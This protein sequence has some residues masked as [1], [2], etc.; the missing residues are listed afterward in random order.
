M[1]RVL[2]GLSVLIWQ[3]AS[4][5]QAADPREALARARVLYNQG[6]FDAAVTA[7]EEARTAP[8]LASAADLIAARAELERHRASAAPDD[9]VRARER[10]GRIDP[11][12]FTP[13]ERLEFVVGLGQALYFDG[14]TGA[15]AVVFESVLSGPHALPPEARERVLDW[16]ANA[17]DRDAHPRPDIE[18]QG[19]YQRIRDRMASEL[20]AR[21]G[22]S[23]ASYWVSAAARG[24][25][26]LQAA[27]D[28]AQAAWVN[29][30][31]STD[32]GV[33]LRADLD[34]LME[35]AIIPERS[36]MLALPPDTLTEEWRRFKEKWT[37][38]PL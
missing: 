26:D 5:A 9:L 20:A 14:S 11:R 22:N 24:Q 13:V 6:Q 10:L 36:R 16:W 1:R 32:S 34:L 33:A 37:K 12:R 21:P 19:V 29:A 3:C 2:V 8:D 28:A 35:R 27:W 23:V 30:S 31:L 38:P 15:S 18:R 7:A 17:L 4:P 25:G